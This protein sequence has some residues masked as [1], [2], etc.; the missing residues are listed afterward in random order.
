MNKLYDIISKQTDIILDLCCFI[1]KKGIVIPVEIMEKIK[2][3]RE[4]MMKE[5]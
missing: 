5:V 4:I 3:T 1:T 2:E